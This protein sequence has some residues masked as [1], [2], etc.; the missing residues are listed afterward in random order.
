MAEVRSLHQR[1][2]DARAKLEKDIDVWVATG[3]A[4]R[5]HLVPLSLCWDGSEVIVAVERKSR[6]A[7]NIIAGGTARLGLGATRDVVMV[8]VTARV[9]AC[10][11]APEEVV[12]CYVK[13][14]GWNPTK[15]AEEFVFLCF[16]PVRIQVWKELPEIS[17]RTVMRDGEWLTGE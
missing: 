17:G 2:A 15:Q 11:E 1:Q 5:G 12:T 7:Q 16:R 3:H 14:T 6:T 8:D 13:R 9:I 10:A 4:D